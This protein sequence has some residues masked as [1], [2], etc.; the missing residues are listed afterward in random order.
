LYDAAAAALAA[1]TASG[2]PVLVVGGQQLAFLVTTP[3]GRAVLALPG[4][5]V[6]FVRGAIQLYQLRSVR[7]SYI[8]GILIQSRGQP[9]AAP[10]AACQASRPGLRPFPE[11]RRLPG[12]F[13]G[14]CGNCK[15]RDHAARCTVRDNNDGRPLIDNGPSDDGG[16]QELVLGSSAANPIVL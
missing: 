6:P 16:S 7:P 14:C 11:C 10:C 15:W 9:V 12:H 3:R 1:A 13:G 5:D 8:H 4:V 2:H